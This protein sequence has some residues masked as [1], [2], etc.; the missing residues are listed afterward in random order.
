MSRKPPPTEDEIDSDERAAKEREAG[1]FDGLRAGR[2]D[3]RNA[4]RRSLVWHRLEITAENRIRRVEGVPDLTPEPVR[5]PDNPDS[6]PGYALGW[7]EGWARG[8]LTLLDG[9]RPELLTF[10]LRPSDEGRVIAIADIPPKSSAAPPR[11]PGRLHG[12]LTMIRRHVD[13]RT[14][15]IALGATLIS[16]LGTWVG[17]RVTEPAV[18]RQIAQF[19]EPVWT[20][21]PFWD[22]LP[23]QMRSL[24]HIIDNWVWQQER[25]GL[26]S[27]VS[28]LISSV[29]AT[30]GAD[31]V[32]YYAI[33]Y[34]QD[35]GKQLYLNDL[36]PGLDPALSTPETRQVLVMTFDVLLIR[37]GPLAM[38]P[39]IKGTLQGY[40]NGAVETDP[41]T[42]TAL[43]RTI[44]ALTAAGL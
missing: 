39:G 14:A 17:L 26:S 43:N 9:L 36:L 37:L 12:V 38:P 21:P 44:A 23:P 32:K 15:V 13:R 31:P 24:F 19:E 2:A 3:L 41:I 35:A 40:L 28:T 6:D 11:A 42:L 25:Q 22:H 29:M 4:L 7:S 30:P 18:S 5:S 33:R 20:P 16:S 10:G 34:V 1:I 27:Q 8:R